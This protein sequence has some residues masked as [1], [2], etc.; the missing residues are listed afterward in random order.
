MQKKATSISDLV[1]DE[2]LKTRIKKLNPRLQEAFLR[3]V[4]KLYE[5]ESQIM[6]KFIRESRAEMAM[7][8]DEISSEQN[9]LRDTSVS[10]ARNRESKMKGAGKKTSTRKINAQDYIGSSDGDTISTA[11]ESSETTISFVNESPRLDGARSR[12]PRTVGAPSR[13]PPINQGHM[14][15]RTDPGAKQ[16]SRIDS[17][18]FSLPGRP[19]NERSDTTLSSSGV[20]ISLSSRS[21]TRSSLSPPN[22]KSFEEE[23]EEL[24]RDLASVDV[25]MESER[26]RQ[27]TMLLQ[28]KEQKK[29]KKEENEEM[30]NELLEQTIEHLRK[31]V[32]DKERQEAKIKDILAMKRKKRESTESE[33]ELTRRSGE[34]LSAVMEEPRS[35]PGKYAIDDI[36]SVMNEKEKRKK[37][38]E[39]DDIAL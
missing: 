26:Q 22:P 5:R 32:I 33:I 20:E 36:T 30:V 2:E 39:I 23:K 13:L 3:S 34:G 12:S 28:R 6:L 24:L 4:E 7:T 14:R 17:D 21:N 8:A 19:S 18:I 1:D 10:M 9:A 11:S 35:G 27:M 29:A 31:K 37:K 25:R 38:K 16:L 15:S